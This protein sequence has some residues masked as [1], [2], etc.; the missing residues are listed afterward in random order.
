MSREETMMLK[1]KERRGLAEFLSNSESVAEKPP[2]MF[3]ELPINY[4]Q[5][6]RFQPRSAI[7][8]DDIQ[9]LQES[10]RMLGVLEPILV[11]PAEDSE[12]YEI[13]AGERRWRAAQAAGLSRVPVIIRHVNDA[14][15]AAIALVENLQRKDL[16]PLEEARGL[17]QL[18]KEY[19]F[20]Q[21]EVGSL[22]G[23]SQPMVSKTLALLELDLA[24][25]VYL[26]NR[27]LDA[28]HGILLLGLDAETQR[29]L[30]ERAAREGWSSRELEKRKSK[31]IDSQKSTEQHQETDQ[32]HEQ[33]ILRLQKSIEE[34]LGLPVK[35]NYN[36]DT[37]IGQIVIRFQNLNECNNIIQYFGVKVESD[38]I[39][40]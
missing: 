4:L 13:L 19:G 33:N 27:E 29:L 31:V 39:Q 20:T 14:T 11:R 15:A 38:N 23:K 9:D 2:L 8:D 26:E 24:V 16:N 32:Q 12:K 34:C 22:T 17:H 5:A 36:R 7:S 25:Q 28:Y 10:I 37:G 40:R 35:L 3:D 1:K 6:G 21:K 18:I 30:A